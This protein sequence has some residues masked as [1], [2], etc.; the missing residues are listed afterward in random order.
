MTP[1]FRNQILKL[2]K[3]W[4][5]R[6]HLSTGTDIG[7]TCSGW[8]A[9]RCVK[10]KGNKV[11]LQVMHIGVGALVPRY[12]CGQAGSHTVNFSTSMS[13]IPMKNPLHPKAATTDP[14]AVLGTNCAFSLS[15][16]VH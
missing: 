2:Q 5:R 9:Y 15:S 7:K 13:P 3:L 14:T 8:N 11:R 10:D 1:H 12:G 6:V 16:K 4:C